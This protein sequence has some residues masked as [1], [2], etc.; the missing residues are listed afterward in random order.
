MTTTDDSD[1]I[2][3][4]ADRIYAARSALAE[5]GKTVRTLGVAEILHFLNDPQ[6]SLS[7]EEQ[8]AL[9]ANP[10]L[11]AD[12]QRLKSQVSFAEL[13]ALAAASAGDV[14]SRRFDGG[15]VSIHPSRMA[16]QTYVRMRFTT[17][18]GTP[19]TMLLEGTQGELI[20]RP[21]PPADA[22][23]EI[24]IVLDERNALDVG[25]LRL[26]SDPTSTGAFLI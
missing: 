4:R 3:R 13:P 9:F 8:R 26:I 1:E 23:G 21:L 22:D 14:K 19:R 16:G 18:A 24:M 15:T 10:R 17:T 7:M 2:A 6:R 20:K 12:Y 11:R 25:F 5:A